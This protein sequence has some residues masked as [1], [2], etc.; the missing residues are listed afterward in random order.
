MGLPHSE[1]MNAYES[2]QNLGHCKWSWK[3][4]LK[5][6][7]K[8]LPWVSEKAVAYEFVHNVTQILV[9]I[10]TFIWRS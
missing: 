10:G 2:I 1:E 8:D 4:M 5:K 6:G 9:Q 3:Y 7:R